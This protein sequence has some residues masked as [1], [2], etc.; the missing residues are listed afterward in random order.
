MKKFYFILSFLI[1]SC[2]AKKND[3]HTGNNYK[4]FKEEKISDITLFHAFNKNDTLVFIMKNSE[5]LYCTKKNYINK[6]Y[7]LDIVHLYTNM[8]DTVYFIHKKLDTNNS[9][10]INSSIGK[11]GEKTNTILT[12]NNSPYLLRDCRNFVD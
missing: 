4:I 12:Y 7:D 2:S 10:K 5:L 9:L 11:P 1:I 6:K 8:N 3:F